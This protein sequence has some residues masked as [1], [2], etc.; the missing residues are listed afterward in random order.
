[1]EKTYSAS[2]ADNEVPILHTTE[3]NAKSSINMVSG[4]DGGAGFGVTAYPSEAELN[5]SI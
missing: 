3:H 5:G 2:A 4:K 1:M